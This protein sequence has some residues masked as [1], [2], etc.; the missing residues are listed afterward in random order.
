MKN[1]TPE[2][3]YYP[4]SLNI[5]GRKCVVVGGGQVA[6]RK[7]RVLLKHGADVSVISPDLCPEL[8]SL[9]ERRE[10][11][12]LT[13]EYRAGDLK[14]AFIAIVATNNSEVNQQVVSEARRQAVLVNVVDDAENSEFIVPSLLRRGEVT[15]AIS[16]SGK[17]PALARK[18]RTRLEKEFGDEYAQLARLIGKVRAEAAG[19]NI[20]VDGD[21][22][23]EAIDLELL[24]E[25][26][27]R[28]EAEK[29]STTLLSNLKARQQKISG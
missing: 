2:T 20:K 8:V 9:A 21:G 7:V 12:V 11:R 23:Q 4:V 25:L 26:L 16:T 17:S 10:I 15:I 29:A 3:V 19:L 28:G 24:L 14:G 5:R 1:N 13:R 27:R 22:W 6:L 18:I